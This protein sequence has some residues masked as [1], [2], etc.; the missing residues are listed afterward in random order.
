LSFDAPDSET[1]APEADAAGEF[2][3]DDE[4]GFA[5]ETDAV[6]NAPAQ[7]A[8]EPTAE[9]EPASNAAVAAVTEAAVAAYAPDPGLAEELAAAR[10][11]VEA[12]TALW[13]QALADLSEAH[14]ELETAQARAAAL[15]AERDQLQAACHEAETG[16]RQLAAR[17][18]LLEGQH[19]AAEQA[20][21]GELAAARGGRPSPAADAELQSLRAE[22]ATAQA[23]LRGL[24]DQA[25]AEAVELRRQLT[26]AL[27]ENE[28]LSAQL[29]EVS[30]PTT[31]LNRHP[32]SD[33][34]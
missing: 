2:D 23:A 9:P 13:R 22:L 7:P 5:D 33:D 21:L 26:E 18:T 4:A 8:P 10:E 15:E 29:D 25:E 17:L 16:R 32:D 11:E 19:A 6:S 28:R 31:P 3:G 30:L 1:P 27:A 24:D 12:R 34:A 14:Q 20:L